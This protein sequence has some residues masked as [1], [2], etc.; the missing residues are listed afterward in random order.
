MKRLAAWI[1]LV[2]SVAGCRPASP[3][4]VLTPET[5]GGAIVASGGSPNIT[6]PILPPQVAGRF[7]PAD[8]EALRQ[9]VADLL[10]AARPGNRRPL[11]LLA[12][13][14]G[15]VY[16]GPVAAAA[17]RQAEG[18]E[19]DVVVV[20][21]TNH[22]HADFEG[23]AVYPDGAL[24]TPLGN[25]AVDAPLARQLI[26]EGG[27][28]VAAPA[29]FEGEHSV[30]VQLP[31][32]QALFPQ[33]PILPL[34]VSSPTD[35]TVDAVAK[36]LA[37]V[38]ANRRPLLVASS[39]LSHY[40]AQADAVPVDRAVLEAVVSMDPD[41]LRSTVDEAMARGIPNLG[42]C[43]CGEGAILAVMA[44][45]RELGSPSA[46]II[47]QRTSADVALGDPDQVVGYGA[48]AFW[49]PEAEPVSRRAAGTEPRVSSAGTAVG[50]QPAASLSGT[51]AVAGAQAS[52]AAT[53]AGIPP[54]ASLAGT[55]APTDR[56]TSSAP[57]AT[58][59]DTA[60]G[61][62]TVAEQGQLLEL[63]R[64]TLEEYLTT[65]T[66]PTAVPTSPRLLEKRGAFVTLT[67]NGELRGCMGS[68]TAQQPLY[69]QVQESALMAALQDPRFPPVTAD[70]LAGLRIEISALGPLERVTDVSQIQVGR[71]GLVIEKGARRGTLLPQVPLEYGWDRSQFLIQLC[72][73]AGL[74]DDAWGSATLY[75][76]TAQVFGE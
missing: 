33:T 20:L 61:D 14:A 38:L 40:P 63:A 70:E 5:P 15:Y 16:S 51:A 7:Y 72:R 48:V 23:V 65:R 60:A 34:I 18:Q 68:L 2:L 55:P 4:A 30:E 50:T 9:T 3:P 21:G 64:R 42:T 11:G 35:A 71:H 76:Y 24:A 27:P 13:H 36:A 29:I 49:A 54:A 56:R 19:Y 43:A 52:I 73:K 10:A 32:L 25:A 74:P 26:G 28:I 17:Y 39:D 69:L 45:A 46:S 75:R 1:A 67:K 6:G 62:L 22:S 66:M 53:V 37:R 12:P 44:V 31:F 41:R 59:T 58:R 47:D 8:P 57:T